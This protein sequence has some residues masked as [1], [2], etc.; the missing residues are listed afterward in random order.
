M[1]LVSTHQLSTFT[2][3]VNGTSPIDANQVKGNDN[4][5]KTS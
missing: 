2:T 5:I 1:G 4:S 3:P